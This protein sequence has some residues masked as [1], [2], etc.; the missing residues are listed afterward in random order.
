M[1]RAS[2][3]LVTGLL[4]ATLAVGVFGATGATAATSTRR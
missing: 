3:R 4:T 1:R 2:T